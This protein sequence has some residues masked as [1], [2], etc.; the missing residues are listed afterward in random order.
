MNP[1]K[2][3]SESELSACLRVIDGLPQR[4]R[5]LF[6]VLYESGARASEVLNLSKRDL[7]IDDRA[8]FI[9]TIKRGKDRVVPLSDE[10][11]RDLIFLAT[12][13]RSDERIFGISYKRFW[14][15]WDE[16]RPVR[17][18]LHAFRH[19]R[20]LGVYSRTKDLKLTQKFLGHRS[21]MSTHVYLDYAYGVD[22]LRVALFQATSSRR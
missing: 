20:A 6:R 12:N 7:I 9:Q 19:T 8:I 16:V 13:L 5:V 1:G 4:D 18:G 10:L 21:A 3:F 2:Y 15:I 14:E 22:E 11:F 17:K